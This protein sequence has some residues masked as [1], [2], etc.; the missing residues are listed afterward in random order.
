[1]ADNKNRKYGR[2]K[3]ACKAYASAGTFEKNQK[4]KM[5]R[6]IRANPMDSAARQRF[7]LTYGRAD[8]VG[9]SGAGRKLQRR[10]EVAAL[11]ATR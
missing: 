2:M 4:R 6:H 3:L 1:M 7:E 11:R 9:L 5:R 10:H 8:S